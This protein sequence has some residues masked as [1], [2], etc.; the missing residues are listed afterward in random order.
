LTDSAA[1]YETAGYSDIRSMYMGKPNN[2]VSTIYGLLLRS[3][4]VVKKAA[5]SSSGETRAHYKYLERY[6]ENSLN[7]K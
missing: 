3:R 1:A 2:A 4:D 6:I 7:A 5:S